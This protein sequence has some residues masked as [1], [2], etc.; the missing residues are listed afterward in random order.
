MM[1]RLT[2]RCGENM[3]SNEEFIAGIYEKAAYYTE[4]KEREIIKVNLASRAV[5]M[6]AMFA[7][8]IGLT[9]FGVAMLSGEINGNGNSA[10]PGEEHGIALL[11]DDGSTGE[12]YAGPAAYRTGP[13]AEWAEITGTIESVDVTKGVVWIELL[14]SEDSQGNAPET[15][16]VVVQWNVLEE[17]PADL[18]VGN[19]VVVTGAAG[20]YEDAESERNGAAKVILSDVANLWFWSEEAENYFNLRGEERP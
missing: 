1:D 9:G 7:V 13:V 14:F 12:A 8:C 20:V 19:R 11:S 3:K 17:M 16:Y 15:T 6:A 4:E 18:Y 10:F 5:K 2:D